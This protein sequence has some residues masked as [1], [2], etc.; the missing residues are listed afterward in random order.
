MFEDDIDT[1]EIR[2]EISEILKEEES[3]IAISVIDKISSGEEDE[4]RHSFSPVQSKYKEIFES[5]CFGL[6]RVMDREKV[7]IGNRLDGERCGDVAVF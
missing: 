2:C 4:N 1:P 5:N 3:P 6:E 7:S